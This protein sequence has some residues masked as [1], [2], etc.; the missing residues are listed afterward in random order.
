MT[1][2]EP[3]RPLPPFA[4][5][6]A[7]IALAPLLLAQGRRVRRRITKL[8]E[9]MGP[10]EGE[11]GRG[12]TMGLLILG[13]SAA[14]GVGAPS[15]DEALGGQLVRALADAHTVRWRVVARDGATTAG[16]IRRLRALDARPCDAAVVSLGVNDLTRGVPVGRWL[17]QLDE[18]DALLRERFGVRRVVLSGMPPVHLFPAL[19]HPLRWY[20]GR[21]AARF[22][23]ALEGWAAAHPH[24]THLVLRYPDDPSFI[25]ED[26]FHPGPRGYAWWADAAARAL[27]A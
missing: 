23:Q 25:A 14:A 15:Q 16:T 12:P 19:P 20:L 10:R 24:R 17:A 4:L 26:G 21:G 3:P 13:D 6:V 22:E 1:V 7:R 8:S 9:A 2:I 11:T 18:L 27:L 5:S